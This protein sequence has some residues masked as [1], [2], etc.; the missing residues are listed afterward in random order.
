METEKAERDRKITLAI[1]LRCAETETL[2]TLFLKMNYS[3]EDYSLT[4][5]TTVLVFGSFFGL[6]TLC[7]DT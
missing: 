3:L 4:N 7:V 1:K 5:T 6:C 2:Q